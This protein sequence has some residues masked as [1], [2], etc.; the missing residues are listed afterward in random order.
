MSISRGSIRQSLFSVIAPLTPDTKVLK[1]IRIQFALIV[2]CTAVLALAYY[3]RTFMFAQG[4]LSWIEAHYL[5]GSFLFV[6]LFILVVIFALPCTSILAIGCGF[7]YYHDFGI[8]GLVIACSIVWIGCNLGA[9]AAFFLSRYLFRDCILRFAE[10]NTK[11]LVIETII[12]RHGLKAAILIRLSPI[13]P[14]VITNY[15]FGVTSIR[16]LHY[17]LGLIAILPGCIFYPFIGSTI[18]ELSDISSAQSKITDSPIG[19]A[20]GI[21][22]IVITIIALIVFA[23]VARRKF[24]KIERELAVK[25]SITEMLAEE[26]KRFIIGE[27]DDDT[28]SDCTSDIMSC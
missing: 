10:D 22:G 4:I 28:A 15:I 9:I 14:F 21:T 20:I 11:F 13:F 26:E 23:L 24:K 3:N 7:I 12:E 27:T 5:I 1:F 16:S 2:I 17:I 8:P 18:S 6:L 19:L 25:Q